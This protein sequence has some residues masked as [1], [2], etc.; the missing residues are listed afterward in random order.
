MQLRIGN[1]ANICRRRVAFDLISRNGSPMPT[2][3][4]RFHLARFATVLS[5]LVVAFPAITLA[6]TLPYS[7]TADSETGWRP[8]EDLAVAAVAKFGI[9]LRQIGDK[10]YEQAYGNFDPD[11]R[12]QFTAQQLGEALAQSLERTGQMTSIRPVR[13]TWTKSRAGAALSGTY[14]A[15]DFAETFAMARRAATSSCTR[16]PTTRIG[17]SSARKITSSPMPHTTHWS[18]RVVPIGRSSFGF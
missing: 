12:A 8:T 14:V 17:T 15:V 2:T 6:A 4:R 10:N 5:A 3:G 16:D 13:M 9:V 18:S 1:A 11:F 7:V